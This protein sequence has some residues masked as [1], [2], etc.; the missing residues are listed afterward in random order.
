LLLLL[1]QNIDAGALVQLAGKLGDEFVN[2]GQLAHTAEAIHELTGL[3]ASRH[4]VLDYL[5]QLLK[6]GEQIV[7]LAWSK[8]SL[9]RHHL[10]MADDMTILGVTLASVRSDTPAA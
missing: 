9:A 8:H 6:L 7:A 3:D 2:P 4:Q 1:H 5:D 10:L